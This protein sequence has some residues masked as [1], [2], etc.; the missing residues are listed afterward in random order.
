MRDIT[1]TQLAEMI[2]A[3]KGALFIGISS[4]TDA[5]AKKTGKKRVRTFAHISTITVKNDHGPI[6][7]KAR[8]V[9]VSGADYAGAVN[10]AGA[11]SFEAA[12]LPWGEFVENSGRK[13]ISHKGGFYLRFQ[14][15]GEQR[16]NRPAKVQYY[17][18]KGK[19][20]HEQV[21]PFLPPTNSE[22]Q[23]QAGV[24]KNKQVHV[25]SMSFESLQYIRLHGKTWRVVPD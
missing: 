1:Y 23:A 24:V 22:K 25:R 15:T 18:N 5:R 8:F 13:L 4:I 6:I 16:K 19:L 2:K 3:H 9:G 12:P 17:G 20:S 21:E 14:S 11:D 10:R 7:K